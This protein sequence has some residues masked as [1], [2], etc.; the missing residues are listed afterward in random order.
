M[1]IR[2]NPPECWP[3]AG[4][5]FNHGVVEPAGRRVHLTGQVAWD[6]A[7]QLVGGADA[8]AQ[9]E[10]CVF[11]IRAILEP[12]GGRLEDIVSMTVYFLDPA[13]LPAIQAVRARHFPAETAPASIL[14]QVSGLVAPELKVELVPIAV[15]PEARFRDPAAPS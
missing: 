7:N 1:T 15:I 10:R 12:M 9:M 4:R 8:A 2:F 5:A 3:R 13:D 11:N 6:G 14:I